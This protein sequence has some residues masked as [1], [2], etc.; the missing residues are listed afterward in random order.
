MFLKS[1]NGSYKFQIYFQ[2]KIVWHF[3]YRSKNSVL[4]GLFQN[5]SPSKDKEVLLQ[6]LQK[7]SNA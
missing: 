7:T 5:G 4:V 2:K 3:S 6:I 1:Q